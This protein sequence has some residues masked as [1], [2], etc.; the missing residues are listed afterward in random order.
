MAGSV[1][2]QF[3]AGRRALVVDPLLMGECGDLR[4]RAHQFNMMIGTVG[5]R[6]LG[7]QAAQILAV[8]Q[9]ARDEFDVPVSILARGWNAS[10]AALAA[11]ALAD[12]DSLE[13][14][15]AREAPETLKKLVTD[16]MGYGDAP[17]LY[18]FGLLPDFDVPQLR[19]LSATPNVEV[20]SAPHTRR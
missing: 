18:C 8:A 12:D 2:E 14:V 5:E 10:V 17:A 15:A 13:S 3:E 9:W 7:I 6:A 20:T 4:D 19:A 11:G 1:T 16:R